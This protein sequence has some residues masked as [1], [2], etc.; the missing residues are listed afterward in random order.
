MTNQLHLAFL[1]LIFSVVFVVNFR[2]KIGVA[3]SLKSRLEKAIVA[4]KTQSSYIRGLA[5]GTLNL[6]RL[7]RSKR[8]IRD[9]IYVRCEEISSLIKTATSIDC[10]VH[11]L[12]DRK[13]KHDISWIAV[14]NHPNFR[15]TILPEANDDY[16]LHWRVGRRF[17][18][19]AV[20]QQRAVDKI[21]TIYP[22]EKGFIIASL[23][24]DT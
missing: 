12:D 16:N 8:S 22:R 1:T 21:N 19:W 13:T 14:I 24:I 3:D 7:Y 15:E 6:H 10:R 11:V 2:K 20:D 17:I 4:V 18:V 9:R 5:R 23:N